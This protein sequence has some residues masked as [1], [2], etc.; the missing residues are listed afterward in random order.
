MLQP[1]RWLAPIRPL[2]T[3]HRAVLVFG[4][5]GVANT[6]LHTATVVALV[7]WAGWAPVAANAAGF[8]IAN[9]GSYFAN[10]ALAFGLPPSWARYG[11]FFAVSLLS[12]A[13]TLA[14]SAFAVGM[15]W[16]YL[17]G[18]LLVLLCGPPLTFLLHR[19]YTFGRT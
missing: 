10:S 15:H 8:A 1:A 7:V 6:L 9:T 14:L 4:A 16:H 11:K 18:L 19:A 2:L 3:R 12:L 13:L 5:I 17:L